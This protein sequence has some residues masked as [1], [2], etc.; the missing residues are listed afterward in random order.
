MS[1][2]IER[3][4]EAEL[5]AELKGAQMSMDIENIAFRL[6]KAE[7]D[8]ASPN[9]GKHLI[10]EMF[11]VCCEEIRARWLGLAS[12]VVTCDP[13]GAA[14]IVE[15]TNWRGVTA[16][17]VIRPIRMWWGK[18]EWHPE[19]WVLTA[20]DCEKNRVRDF[21]WQDMRPVANPATSEA[22]KAAIPQPIPEGLVQPVCPEC[23]NT[24]L[25]DAQIAALVEALR[26]LRGNIG[27]AALVKNSVGIRVRAAAD[28]ALAAAKGGDA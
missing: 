12:A 25:R 18:T 6:W 4:R 1:G 24:G 16:L 8:R 20:Y 10:P 2:G 23:Q 26:D 11:A 17:R 15:Y 9:V 28:A 5:Y 3:D 19:Q 22:V 13:N 7:V 27:C 21:A 14:Q